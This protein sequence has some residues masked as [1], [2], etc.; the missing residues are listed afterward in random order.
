KITLGRTTSTQL[1][2]TV[3]NVRAVEIFGGQLYISTSSGSSVRV[4]TVGSG[5]PTSSGQTISN[6]PGFPTS[7]SPYAFYFADLSS[8]VSGVDTLYV[9]DDTA[10]QIQK[11]SL[12]SGSWTSN[13]TIS[14][15]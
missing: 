5:T 4:G 15:T 11:F 12:V 8:S 1:S 9:A 7:G 3:S 14:A 2:T 10:N 13:G 6:L